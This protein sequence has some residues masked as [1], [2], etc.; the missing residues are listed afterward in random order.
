MYPDLAL[1]TVGGSVVRA[2]DESFAAKENLIVPGP[3]VF[4]PTTFGHRGKVYDGWE[5]R[6]RR[7]PGEDQAVVRLGAPGIVRRIVVDTTWFTG[8]HPPR[9][10]VDGRADGD[11]FELV[12]LSDLKGDSENVFDVRCHRRADEVRLRIVPDGGVAR[13]RVF[14]EALPD[15]ALLAALGTVDLAAVENGGHIRDVSNRFYSEPHNLLLPGPA[16]SM[17]EG[18]ETAR[19]RDAGNDW[20]EI[21]LAVESSLAVVELDTR[22]FLHNAPARA[23]LRSGGRTLLESEL[24]PD[25]VHRVVPD[26]P[27]PVT[28]VRLDIHPDGGLSRVRLWGTPTAG[29]YRTLET[30]WLSAR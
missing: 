8:N 10:A 6:R 18:W 25:T 29:G 13:L 16:R 27:T 30:R 9:A 7:T 19:R 21:G 15:P 12:T 3:P 17:G 28:A 1:R 24:S 4:D 5:T 2:S 14:G 22:Y 20:V 23:V 26:D 11:W